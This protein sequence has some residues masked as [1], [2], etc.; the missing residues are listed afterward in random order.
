MKIYFVRNTTDGSYLHIECE[1]MITWVPRDKAS[2][3]NTQEAA[4][5]AGDFA[6]DCE[7]DAAERFKIVD[8]DIDAAIEVL[9]AL[10][11]VRDLGDFIYDIR[12]REAL[13][14]EGP[15]VTKWSDAVTRAKILIDKH[16]ESTQ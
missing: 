10:N 8:V 5:H 6:F 14:W 11:E 9:Q 15:Q 13:G 2:I 4:F 7:D 3:Y 12:E 16:R 1:S